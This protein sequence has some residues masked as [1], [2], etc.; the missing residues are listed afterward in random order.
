MAFGFKQ[1]APIDTKPGVAVGVSVLFNNSAVFTS[2]Y[3][4]KDAVKNNLINYLLT[5]RGDRYDNPLF[6]GDLRKYVFEQISDTTI[7]TIKEDVSTT[8]QNYFPIIDLENVVILRQPDTNVI[9]VEIYYT[10]VT[11]GEQDNIVITFA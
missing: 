5:N 9:F 1:I 6:G 8:I 2:T 10:L 11:T 7:D 3:T 4:T